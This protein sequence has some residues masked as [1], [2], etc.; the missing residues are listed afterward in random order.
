MSIFSERVSIQWEDEPSP[1]EPTSTWVLTAAN[2]DFVDTRIN[3]TTKIPEW[4]STGKELEIETKPGYEYSIN[5][6]LIL[7]STSEPNS[8]NSDVGNFKQLPNSNYRLEEGSMANP[9]QNKKIMSYKE[10][11]RTLDP[12][13]S[14]P[15]NLVEIDT[16]SISEKEEIGFESKVW[17][18][19]GN[20]GR[21]ITI[22]YFGQGVAVN[23][24]YE[25][26]TI[27][28]YKNRVLYS[29]GNDYQKIFAP[30]LGKGISGMEWIQKC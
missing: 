20:R 9:T 18:L 14:T 2:G 15:E 19:P 10:I 5:F 22:G 16:G 13:R 8:C 7:D 21:F 28:L 12:N 17:E 27:R 25:Y 30:F 23:E 3:L 6:Q 29:D 26:Q 1:N 24:N 11:W 4:V